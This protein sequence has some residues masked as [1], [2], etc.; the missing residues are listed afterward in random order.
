[1]GLAGM[2]RVLPGDG[3][4]LSHRGLAAAFA[5]PGP[6]GGTQGY[7]QPVESAHVFSNA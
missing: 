2:Q 6:V 3:V 1:M 7:K 4:M 5:A